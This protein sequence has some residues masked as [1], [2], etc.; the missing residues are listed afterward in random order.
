M[1]MLPMFLILI[2]IGYLECF[3]QLK[4]Y[5]M[6]H[7]RYKMWI[8]GIFALFCVIALFNFVYYLNQYFVQQNYFN[9]AD[10]QYGY[11][12]AVSDIERMQGQYQ[13]IVV[14]DKVP[15]DESYMFFLFY[16]RYPP[17]QYQK[18]VAEGKNLSTNDH[19]F[20]KYDFRS[21]DWTTE[22]LKQ[23]ILYV[24]SVGD[25]PSNVVAKETIDYPDGS[26]VILIAD[27]KDN[28][29]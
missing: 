11:A 23:N 10:W 5:Q 9:A 28:K 8:N 4:K 22:K 15:L 6:A 16:L 3:L 24:G 14:S 1:N 20:G 12:Q 2:A 21:F 29:K 25:F 13:K 7:V 26:P 18:L 17:Q 19:T 27:P